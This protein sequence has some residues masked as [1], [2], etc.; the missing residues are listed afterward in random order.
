[1]KYFLLLFVTYSALANEVETCQKFKKEVLEHAAYAD[2]G[3]FYRDNKKAL[4]INIQLTKK[5]FKIW[6][7]KLKFNKKPIKRNRTIQP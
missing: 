2:K 6:I 1:M 3:D 7:I 4:F 5:G